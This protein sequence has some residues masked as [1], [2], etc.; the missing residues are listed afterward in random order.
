[1]GVIQI[2]DR[3]ESLGNIGGVRGV[4]TDVGAV[5]AIGGIA[6]AN[7]RAEGAKYRKRMLIVRRK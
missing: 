7:S 3:R 6:E 5:R 4:N 1:M 2:R